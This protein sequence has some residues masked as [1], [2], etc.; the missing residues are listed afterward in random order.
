MV[1]SH[2]EAAM[3][4][5]VMMMMLAASYVRC[6]R[7]VTTGNENMSVGLVHNRR[8]TIPSLDDDDGASITNTVHCSI[9][10]PDEPPLLLLLLLLRLFLLLVRM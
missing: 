2:Y 8:H 6:S 7:T 3:V 9:S 5:M 1:P 10:A 4:M